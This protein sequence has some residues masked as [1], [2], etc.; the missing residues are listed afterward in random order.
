MPL[1][2]RDSSTLSILGVYL[3]TDRSRGGVGM[4]CA[5][6]AL[7]EAS[8]RREG[9]V[10]AVGAGQR[11]PAVQ[12][13]RGGTKAPEEVTLIFH[14]VCCHLLSSAISWLPYTSRQKIGRTKQGSFC[15]VTSCDIGVMSNLWF[16]RKVC[17]IGSYSPPKAQ[18]D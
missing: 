3:N 13:G 9:P 12:L 8:W 14:L 17:H 10:Y 16:C 7:L 4:P 15:R 5:A 18:R 11:C 6:L 1:P 2:G